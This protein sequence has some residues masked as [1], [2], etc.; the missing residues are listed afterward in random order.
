MS[1]HLRWRRRR[2]RERDL[3]DELLFHI[4]AHTADLIADGVAPA[5]ARR[6][7]LAVF[8]GTQPIKERTRDA[9]GLPFVRDAIRDI[10][11]G[12]RMLRHHWRFA[13]LTIGLLALGIGANT[14]MFTVLDAVILRPPPYAQADRLVMLSMTPKDFG[15][16]AFGMPSE[17]F[18][19][20]RDADRL[21]DGLA[22]FTNAQAA[23][24]VSGGEPMPVGV[25]AVTSGYFAALGASAAQGRTFIRSDEA[26]GGE[27]VVVLS[28]RLWRN[29]LGG[30]SDVIGTFVA[31][32]D[33]LRRVIGV[34]P[35]NGGGLLRSDAWVP[36]VLHTAVGNEAWPTVIGRLRPGVSR[37][38]A[39]AELEALQGPHMKAHGE[40]ATQWAASVLPLKDYIVGDVRP[41]LLA[42]AAAVGLVLLIVCSNV[43]S[44]FL[45]RTEE[46]ARELVVRAALGAGRTRLMRQLLTESLV[47]SAAGGAAGVLMTF[48][49]L[50]AIASVAERAALP[51]L[52]AVTVDGRVLAF[53]AG[54]CLLS[55]VVF[56]F[57]P[58]WRARRLVGSSMAL[59]RTTTL[60]D[61]RLH[62]VLVVAQVALSLILL[63]GAGLTIRSI[64][65][66]DTGF[67][68]RHLG[69]VTVDMPPSSYPSTAAL[70]GFHQQMLTTLVTL[71]GVRQAAAVNFVP[72]GNNMLAGQFTLDTGRAWPDNEMAYN[73]CV[74]DAYF[75]TMGVRMQTGR[76]FSTADRPDSSKVAIV[77]ASFAREF[78]PGEPA[79]G[80]RLSETD[81]P[82][83]R[84][85]LTVVG[86]VDDAKQSDVEHDIP[87]TVYRPI[88][89][90]PQRLSLAH[91]TF[92]FRTDG[93][94]HDIATS[95]RPIL[96][97]LAPAVPVPAIATMDEL[98]GERLISARFQAQ[99]LGVFALV[100]LLLT[101]IGIFGVLAYAVSR[102]TRELGVRL[103]LGA[104][105]A[106]IV[107]GVLRRSL[108]LTLA[109]VA[110]G[111]AGAWA[112][113]RILQDVLFGIE[114]S[115]PMTFVVVAG[116]L[117]L[118][119]LGA[120]AIPANRASRVDPV[121][122]LRSE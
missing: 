34:M 71:P 16:G 81:R 47:V 25:R 50:R 32:D 103:A 82:T 66:A 11:G 84:D 79:I 92:V 60:G 72:F 77:S 101:T 20:L 83:D 37:P 111:S 36:M 31:V 26:P 93:D 9:R 49:G 65:T 53:A 5:E 38:Q 17:V 76:S 55:T 99:L 113:A 69:T 33:T 30:R 68:T 121:V 45:A 13:A 62:G 117:V 70:A 102:R 107:A 58:A 89:Q 122:A 94:P 100:A 115:D 7:A 41:S 1:W 19:D 21:L 98:V 108:L 18:A 105:R 43:A 91:M 73:L 88:A 118:V 74:S 4:E 40:D 64:R 67:S 44:L 95:L 57:A 119:A 24:R 12:I 15:F 116:A 48:A 85:W 63:V 106:Q 78:W 52:S 114:P 35:P 109:G 90:A 8:G 14:A 51:F 75:Q 46:R 120:A 97:Q 39:A 61:S 86:V 6:R 112:L 3:D 59:G 29:A 87:L 54:L 27:A 10:S 110:A 104:S 28:D 2:P 56:G 96:R 80:H 22:A 42:L 23:L